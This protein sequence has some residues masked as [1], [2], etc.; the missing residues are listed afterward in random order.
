MYRAAGDSGFPFVSFCYSN[1]PLCRVG[2]GSGR[3][4]VPDYT[5]SHLSA[6]YSVSLTTPKF[7]PSVRSPHWAISISSGV[8]KLP[9]HR[10]NRILLHF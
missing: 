6:V 4:V 9:P 8:S 2:A 3:F 1:F 7:L 10:E 5:E